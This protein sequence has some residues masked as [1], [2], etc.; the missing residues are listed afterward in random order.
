MVYLLLQS[1]AQ[2]TSFE[3]LTFVCKQI[4]WMLFKSWKTHPLSTAIIRE[5]V[6]DT[7]AD[8]INAIGD[9]YGQEG[10]QLYCG[11]PSKE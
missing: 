10:R 7:S 6:W 3:E 1:D 4:L 8:D 5:T 11:I 2:L 9:G